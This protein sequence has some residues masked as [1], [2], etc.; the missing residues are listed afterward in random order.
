MSVLGN[1]S[2]ISD[3]KHFNPVCEG[4]AALL[5]PCPDVSVAKVFVD[6]DLDQIAHLRAGLKD[7]V[8]DLIRDYLTI[9]R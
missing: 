4:C 7:E 8:I 1:I 6:G 5:V 2:T 3:S 9:F